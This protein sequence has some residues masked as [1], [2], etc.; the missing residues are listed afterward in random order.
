MEGFL[1]MQLSHKIVYTGQYSREDKLALVRQKFHL[2]EKLVGEVDNDIFTSDEIALEIVDN[3][4]DL[5]LVGENGVALT[6]IQQITGGKRL[7][8]MWGVAGEDYY[9]VAGDFIKTLNQF[10]IQNGC[11]KIYSNSRKAIADN[12]VKEH[13]F[14]T[15]NLILVVREVENVS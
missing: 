12:L 7:V 3:N 11:S 4:L 14:K 9:N 15:K 6:K 10:A 1:A 2:I 13:N 8:E 5:W